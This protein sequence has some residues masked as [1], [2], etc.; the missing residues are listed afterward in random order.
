MTA[1]RSFPAFKWMPSP[2]EFE[3]QKY[4]MVEWGKEYLPDNEKILFIEN[5]PYHITEQDGEIV[6]AVPIKENDWLVLITPEKELVIFPDAHVR[7]F[8][9]LE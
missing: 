7:N 9:I 4:D 1:N 2:L 3:Q 6:T 5:L 8:F